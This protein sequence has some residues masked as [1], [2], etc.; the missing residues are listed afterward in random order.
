M[1]AQ[2]SN[3]NKRSREGWDKHNILGGKGELKIEESLNELVYQSSDLVGDLANA[4]KIIHDKS[5][6]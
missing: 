2:K 6:E 3:G 5:K 1:I 4:S